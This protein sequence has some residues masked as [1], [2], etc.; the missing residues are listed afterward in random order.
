MATVPSKARCST[1]GK[2]KSTVRCEGCLKLFCYNH[3]TDH[4][5]ELSGELNEIEINRDLLRQTLT[6]QAHD[7]TQRILIKKINKWEEDSIKKIHKAAHEYRQL[8][9]QT[10]AENITETELNLAKL[11]DQLKQTRLENDFNEIDLNHLKRTLTQLAKRLDMPP[12]LS[13]KEDSVALIHRISIVL[14]SGHSNPRVIELRKA[15]ESF[16]FHIK[17]GREENSPIYISHVTPYGVAWEHGELRKGDQLLSVNGVSVENE[18][19]ETAVRLLKQAQG[20]VKL[21]VQY[22]PQ[23]LIEMENHFDQ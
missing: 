12:N 15:A 14:S 1:C 6:E 18:Y 4:R 16:G 2:E 19:L 9:L 17:G 7:P 3:L 5:Q 20:M 22:S 10:T 11:T 23:D 13:M 21:V 8:L